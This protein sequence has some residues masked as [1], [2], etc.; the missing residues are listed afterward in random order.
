MAKY[1]TVIDHDRV[2][3]SERMMPIGA[4]P[5]IDPNLANPSGQIAIAPTWPIETPES[6]WLIDNVANLGANDSVNLSGSDELGTFTFS[7]DGTNLFVY[8]T[9]DNTLDQ[10]T[11]GTA[12]DIDTMTLTRSKGLA[13]N[14]TGLYVS[15]DGTYLYA[16]RSE[17]GYGSIYQYEMSTA[18]DISTLTLLQRKSF[19]EGGFTAMTM[20]ANGFHLYA[21]TEDGVVR[22]YRFSYP[23]IL[24]ETY[25]ESEMTITEFNGVPAGIAVSPDGS[26]I[27]VVESNTPGI[28]Q[29][30]LSTDY[31]LATATYENISYSITSDTKVIGLF[32][33]EDDS[34]DEYGFILGENNDTLFKYKIVLSWKVI[35]P[36]AWTY[37]GDF[38]DLETLTGANYSDVVVRDDLGKIFVVA[39]YNIWQFS[40]D[41]AN[42]STMVHEK[43]FVTGITVLGLYFSD[44]GSRMYLHRNIY[45]SG[46][47]LQYVLSTPWDVGSATLEYT[48]ENGI[49]AGGVFS[50]DGLL[51]WDYTT[52]VYYSDT[53]HVRV[54]SL[55][56][57]WDLSTA[58][59]DDTI[60]LGED[61]LSSLTKP[62]RNP[63]G[64]QIFFAHGYS[65]TELTCWEYPNPFTDPTEY[66]ILFSQTNIGDNVW[67]RDFSGDGTNYF[68]GNLTDDRFERW[69]TDAVQV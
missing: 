29:Y 33:Y 21:A 10:Y 46:E 44:D 9:S 65:T 52:L 19:G 69:T 59:L 36:N 61:K 13:S 8:R 7:Q 6:G 17:S 66:T 49:S 38:I 43:T 11:L 30:A 45:R 63:D 2:I 34:D 26:K 15:E 56:S 4:R 67:A 5:Q 55:T 1:A 42:V 24:S 51:F 27:Y 3:Y 35:T 64:S 47:V 48:L 41:G 62:K 60:E 32:I 20:I 16:C 12:F 28:Y 31:F 54:Y 50:P 14:I 18:L 40:Y 25:L 68:R 53:A 22:H 57:A 58:T 23:F 37:T 39:N